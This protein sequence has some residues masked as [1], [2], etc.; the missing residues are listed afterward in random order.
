MEQIELD[1]ILVGNPDLSVIGDTSARTPQNKQ[2]MAFAS[3]VKA[4][5]GSKNVG[6]SRPQKYHNTKTEYG[7]VV[8]H[9]K[10]E[11]VKAQ[12]LDLMVKAGEISF[13]LR[14]VPF[15]LPGGIT[16]RADFLTY[17]R[18]PYPDDRAPWVWKIKVIEVKGIWTP[19][20]KLKLKL[21]REK[22]PH[23][24]LEIC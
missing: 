3:E 13:Y 24:E 2:Q 16:Y 22:Y 5:Y 7:G 20:A 18:F 23:L 11:A 15:D 6:A 10:K 4:L 9:S 17:R 19:E 1:K 21:F 12:E 8:Y 14:Q